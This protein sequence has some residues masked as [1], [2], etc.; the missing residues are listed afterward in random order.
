[1][2]LNDRDG[3]GQFDVLSF[4]C[5]GTLIDWESGILEALRPILSSHGRTL[6]DGEI[7]EL[8]AQVEAKIEAAEYASYKS[9][10]RK[11][12]QQ[13][14]RRLDFV[15]TAAEE[16]SLVISIGNWAPFPDTVEALQ[17]LKNRFRLA[18]ISNV[19]D[20]LFALSARGLKVEFDWIITA[21]Q[22]R[23]YKPSLRNF[24]L[25]I[26]TIGIP[27]NRIL[28][29]AQSIYHDI[30][31]ARSVGIATAWVNRRKGKKGL[32]AT[33]PA[34]GQPDIEVPDLNALVSL[35]GTGGPE[36]ASI[37]TS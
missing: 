24:R 23:S 20:D 17:N 6:G 18:V 21:A 26:E 9:V 36:N 29:V 3:Y 12:V 5:Y 32:G 8:Y 16:G 35:V 25:A 31:P 28:H 19:D 22:A 11:V 34:R 2:K 7:L 27:P 13:V 33:P 4:D 15:P 14:G 1:M 10:L 37:R 30:I